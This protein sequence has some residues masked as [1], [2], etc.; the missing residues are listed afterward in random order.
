VPLCPAQYK[1]LFGT[2]RIPGEQKDEIETHENSNHVA[3]F[4]NERIHI[5]DVCH[6]RTGQPYSAK[7]LEQ[8]FEKIIHNTR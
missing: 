1:R 3:V 5:I 8:S 4:Y 2:V 7:Y 6:D